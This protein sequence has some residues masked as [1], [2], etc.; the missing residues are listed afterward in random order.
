MDISPVNLE[1]EF[2]KKSEEVKLI[3]KKPTDSE[4]LNLY[5]YYKQATIGDCNIKEPSYFNP[6][7][8]AKYFAWKK[9][10]GTSKEDSMNSNISLVN[11]IIKKYSS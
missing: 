2:N 5:Q 8:R 3:K 9:L 7:E 11:G 4:L 10:K 6:K 1:N